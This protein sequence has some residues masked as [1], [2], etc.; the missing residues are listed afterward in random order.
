MT[1]KHI[2]FEDSAVMRSLEKVAREKGL[3]KEE[4]F[5]KKASKSIDLSP[6]PVLFVNLLK[7]AAG[8]RD[9]GWNDAAVE[10]ENKAI[11]YKQAQTLYE[12][13]KEKG[14]DL[15]DAAHP[16]GSHK[17]EGVEGDALFETILDQHLADLE[18]VEKKPTGKLASSRDILKAVRVVLGQDAPAPPAP[19]EEKI[20]EIAGQASSVVTEIGKLVND[21]LTF[22]INPFISE[23]TKLATNPTVYHLNE[24]KKTLE[25]L[26]ERL[27]P[28]FSSKWK[29]FGIGGVSDYTWGR[30]QPLLDK[31]NSLV[32]AAYRMRVKFDTIE[33]RKLEGKPAEEAPKPQNDPKTQFTRAE[34]FGNK[35][36]DLI[37][38]LNSYKSL[39]NDP[40]IQPA[41]KQ[42]GLT[43][44]NQA[45]K[46]LVNYKNQFDGLDA[47]VKIEEAPRF[48]QKLQSLT[49]AVN[50][51]YN[52]FIL[53]QDAT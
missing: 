38:K 49:K 7:L 18:V 8:L 53:G 22:S 44:I 42:Q 26:R 47:Q 36:S 35:V 12:T 48:E 21:E 33:Q 46:V 16:K 23:V 37:S 6:T 28:S 51:F 20:V 34:D 41:V 3:I 11:A 25:R 24:F 10:L 13:S 30:V 17:L 14:E 29:Y 19:T 31:A 39:L 15:V 32:D 50:D 40:D 43:W 9:K 52:Q 4:D 5:I 45:T 1:F 2:K 27:D